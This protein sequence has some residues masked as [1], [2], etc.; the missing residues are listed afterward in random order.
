MTKREETEQRV[1]DM[2]KELKEMHKEKMNL[3]EVQYRLWARTGV[4]SSK[5]NPPQVPM[6][7][8]S[9]PRGSVSQDLEESIISTAATI[10][11]AAVAQ[12]SPSSSVVQ[13]PLINQTISEGTAHQKGLGVSPGK[14]SEIRGKS[15]TQLATLKHLYEDG[16]LT[17]TEFEKQKE[18]ILGGLI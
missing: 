3:S 8:G 14:I 17:L 10:V 1:I 7:T 18:M 13:S 2:A 6:T 12:N 9:I 16:V 11:K 15:Y 5:D 4:H